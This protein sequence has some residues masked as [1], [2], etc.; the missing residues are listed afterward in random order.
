MLRRFESAWLNI[1]TDS[2]N[3]LFDSFFGPKKIEPT[4]GAAVA[5]VVVPPVLFHACCH[6]QVFSWM[7]AGI[8]AFGST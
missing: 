4:F 8:F 1:S 2:S 3:V 7:C 5:G 6:V